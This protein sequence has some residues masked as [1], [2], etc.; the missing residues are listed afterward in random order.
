MNNYNLLELDESIYTDIDF[1]E[2]FKNKNK[3]YHLCTTESGS[4]GA[5]ILNLDT[6]K[7]IGIYKAYN[8]EG[9]YNEGIIPKESINTF[10]KEYR[11][12]LTFNVF[13]FK[14]YEKKYF[15]QNISK[16]N[17]EIKLDIPKLNRKDIIE[18]INDE[19]CE[20]NN[21]FICELYFRRLQCIFWLL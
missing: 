21:Y 9:E 7:V 10:N 11:I 3:I 17:E 19:I 5:P 15:L 8:N 1:I 16:L 13:P 14:V 18:M 12:I 2:K 6:L 4:S 20:Y